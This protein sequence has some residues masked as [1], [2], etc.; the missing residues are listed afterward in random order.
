ML[1]TVEPS[2]QHSA[3]VCVCVCVRVLRASIWFECGHQRTTFGRQF[4]F[5]FHHEAPWARTR[6]TVVGS[7]KHLYSQSPLDGPEE[8]SLTWGRS[9]FLV[10]S[11]PYCSSDQ[12]RLVTLTQPCKQLRK[13][14]HSV[15]CSR[16]H[17]LSSIQQS[18]CRLQT[19]SP[20]FHVRKLSSEPEQFKASFFPSCETGSHVAQAGLTLA[21]RQALY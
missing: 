5:F 3:L 14:L 21:M 8:T 15:G 16:L 9:I 11:L 20:C 18:A 17:S 13:N 1:L 6:I 4:S 2:L 19:H 7:H 12:L 10:F